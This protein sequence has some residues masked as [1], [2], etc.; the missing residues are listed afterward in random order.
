MFPLH[1][2]YEVRTAVLE[3]IKATFRFR[4]RD[5]N[6]KFHEFVA[7][8][9]NGIFKGPY[10]SL[11]TPFVKAQG[12]EI[13]LEIKPL[14][15]PH[16]HQI[17]SF[18]RLTTDKGHNPEPTL[19]TPGT[20]SGKT[21]CF[22]FPVLDYVYQMNRNGI[23][24]GVKV[25]IMYPMNALATDQAK[26][27][28]ETIYNDERL[29]GKVTAG[30]FIGEGNRED[31]STK[32]TADRIIEQRD[33][34]VQTVPDIILTNFKM[35]DYGLM[36][37]RYMPLWKGN[38]GETPMLRFLV[39][40]ELHTYDGAQGTDVA[41]LIRRLKLKLNIPEKHLTP[42]GTSAT[43][44]SG[45]EAIELLTDY[46]STVFGETFDRESII[47]EERVPTEEFF[48]DA[49]TEDQLPSK[50]MLE[51]LDS[52][53]YTDTEKYLRKI[54]KVWLESTKLT[55]LEMAEKLRS[56][57]IVE[58][59]VGV[60]SRGILTVN[61][62]MAALA[63][64]NKDYARIYRETPKLAFSIIESLLA[65]ISM[66]K[67]D[68]N[69]KIV[70]W[71]FLQ[72]Q[73]WQRELSG[74]QRF[75]Q[76]KVEFTWRDAVPKDE[77]I[78]L[79]MWFCRDCGSSG[80]L[81]MKR[82][83]ENR[84]VTDASRIGRALMDKDKNLV[85]LN[86]ETEDHAPI[87]DYT[88]AGQ[89]AMDCTYFVRTEDLTIG[90]KTDD[91]VIKL[92]VLS[93]Q[94]DT[95][96]EA[97]PKFANYCPN[98]M[99]PEIS[100]VGQRTA[101]LSSVAVSQVM[102]SDF[103]GDGKRK[104]LSFTNSVQ[105]AAH[106]AGFYELR[107]FRFLFRQSLQRYIK[108]LSA[109]VSLKALQEG[110]KKYWKE[111]LK[112]N[113]EYYYRFLTDD[114][115]QKIDLRVNYRYP[116]GHTHAGELTDAFKKEFDTRID[117]EIC[118]E[119]GMMSGLGRT[120]EKMGSSATFF[121]IE[122]IREVFEAMK[123]WMKENNL[124]DL[125]EPQREERFLHFVN[126]ILHR[127]RRRGG[128]DHEYLRL[129]RTVSLEPWALNWR[130]Q[131]K[132]HFLHK[133]FGGNRVP[134]MLGVDAIKGKEVLDVVRMTGRKPNWFY[135]YFIKSLFTQDD[136]FMPNPEVINDF[137]VELLE[138]MT[139]HG[140]LD[141]KMAKDKVNYAIRPE[142]LM[143]ATGVREIKCSRC[144]SRL[145]VAKN[146]ELTDDTYCLDFRC[147][148]KYDSPQ[149]MENNYY[150]RIYNR[151]V[152][153]RIHA[154][155]H[156][157]LLER[158]TRENIEQSFKNGD[159]PQSIN[160]LTATSTLEMGIDIGDLNIVGIVGIPPKPSNFQQR[161]G[162]GGRKS[163][164][165]LVL[166]Y[167]KGE[168][169]DMFYFAEPLEMM[170]GAVSTPGCFLEARDILRRHFYA[171]CIDS[172]TSADAGHKL[173]TRIEF[174]P[175]S[176]DSLTDPNFFVN[177]I[178]AYIQA[179]FDNL[180]HAFR[181]QY[182]ASV[183]AVLD[184]L[185]E[186][187]T[188]KDFV[189]RIIGEF[190]RLINRR[191]KIKADREAA[192]NELKKTPKNDKEKIT[193]LKDRYYG[194]KRLERSINEESVVEFMT[195]HGL[196]P[197]YAFP[198]T[199]VA[200]SATIFQGKLLGDDIDNTKEPESVELMRPAS[201]GIR[202]LA[203]GNIFYTQK[204]RL[205]VGGLS[206][207]DED[208][209]RVRFCSRCDAIAFAGSDEFN[210][211]SCPKCKDES[212]RANEHEYLRF[213]EA[214][215]S[216]SKGDASIKDDD[217]RDK[218]QYNII[219]HFQFVHHGP[220]TSYGLK[221]VGF[222]IEFCKD[223]TLIEANC[224]DQKQRAEA[225][226]INGQKG[227]SSLGFVTCKHC[228]KSTP[229]VHGNTK[230]EDLHFRFCNHREVGF[231]EDSAN[232]GTFEKLF[233]Y[234]TMH[235]EA[236]KVLLPVQLFDTEVSLELFKAGIER[237]M[238][239]YYKSNPDHLRIE[240]Y[241]EFNQATNDFD[242]YL[243]IFDTIPGGTGYLSKLFDKA[244]FSKLIKIAYEHIRDCECQREGKD[245]CYHCIL[246]YGNQWRRQNLSR[247]R[248]EE[249]FKSLVDECDNWED[250]SGSVGTITA[251]G[252]IEDSE[253]ELVFVRAMQRIAKDRKWAWTRK[254][255]PLNDSYHY[256]L[257]IKDEDVKIKYT[258]RPQYR[259]GPVNGVE[260]N[261]IPDFQFRCT[262]YERDGED[263]DIQAAPEISV[264]VDGY[265]FHASKENMGFYKDFI[266]REA[267]R[268]ATG[269]IKRLSWTLSWDDLK[270]HTLDEVK[271]SDKA[272]D[273]NRHIEDSDIAAA[274]PS[275]LFQAKDSFERFVKLLNIPDINAQTQEVFGFLAACNQLSEQYLSSY[276]DIDKALADNAR[277]QYSGS[278]PAEDEADGKYF[279]RTD[280]LTPTSLVGGTMWISFF[281]DDA[282]G[283]KPSENIRYDL[284]IK[285]GLTEIN[286][287]D[288][289]DFWNRYNLLQF[290]DNQPSTIAE[291]HVPLDEV[292]LYYPGREEKVNGIYRLG[293]EVD[294]D[295]EGLK[296]ADGIVVAD[297]ELK[298]KDHD[299]VVGDFDENP[300]SKEAFLN[301]G[302]KVLN[303]D[304]LDNLPNLLT[305]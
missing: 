172:W 1:Q 258:V 261:S 257:I 161:V 269:H 145:F 239:H 53:K 34:I 117:W 105:D 142:S 189:N 190:E 296:D 95:K 81:S 119:F 70:P 109:P 76:D 291:E 168:K 12:E 288:W 8:E 213:L 59:L 128:I 170:Q 205:P 163:G 272:K 139:N 146:D 16:L 285:E 289:H 267:I 23:Q 66:A 221:K 166:N 79:P 86:T 227:I 15:D 48:K 89:N 58:D 217:D 240:T 65:L 3:Y 266:R 5:V 72:V 87:G 278:I 286:K 27:L 155:E 96:G 187:V 101:T 293:L 74:I 133:R 126:G 271:E 203:P 124:E 237:G 20:G 43:I 77:R 192:K 294:I 14:F 197:N 250:I 210:L 275:S 276:A 200:F 231:P 254:A 156:T 287:E 108:T 91:N 143:V 193:I 260:K 302:F 39:L 247:Q 185:F 69:G 256:E 207:S 73:L 282:I 164:S 17:K 129:Y 245:G 249:L 283:L 233:L 202:E 183:D 299:V 4:D 186:S 152:S 113:D 118:S 10:I 144:E 55:E 206:L 188:N 24:K 49:V 165:A 103:D 191:L 30:L 90:S 251:S 173:P 263:M 167:A 303:F 300:E 121:D 182:P 85:L 238:Q 252:V 83:T 32:M 196:L 75:I 54:K 50:E 244:E 42:I 301:A 112:E 99:A 56:L 131:E 11:R 284:K 280:F 2:A 230:T 40:D 29:R 26:R 21:E 80:W 115:S 198:E 67:A 298:I 104:M 138:V 111:E 218:N 137:Y 151:E 33:A 52:T 177:Q 201:Q 208:K 204:L 295:F 18:K 37:Q 255:D 92:R 292:L 94:T 169:H 9:R 297:A 45:D 305:K 41:N 141:R 98:C 304:E 232:L 259:L 215:T 28:A 153:P 184:E 148:G 157:G 224:G 174:L 47:G 31:L 160:V 57:K 102:S 235:T 248:A 158:E 171:Y 123:L 265:A 268:K 122:K 62:L 277:S 147:S 61:E 60:T 88:S 120:L 114:F 212:W 68:A 19:L 209:T 262:A 22:L 195:N 242:N 46:A 194:L 216:I 13:P 100:I 135:R 63:R 44:G 84:F 219:K 236:I 35:L 93:R 273:L 241:R 97:V 140:I 180:S 181:R 38:L 150:N 130:R 106:L 132:D 107:T 149:K 64:E 154:H 220:I 264:F 7:D 25:I 211:T 125:A 214:N 116:E 226:E 228:G 279:I 290:F 127:L 51:D 134:H 229:V 178:D 246:S 243:V 234:R 225:I 110:F 179:D 71:L 78:A 176:H 223:V 274:F 162:R 6:D 136:I 159:H 253:L 175:M 222:G 270:L 36:Q 82:V 199:G 281:E